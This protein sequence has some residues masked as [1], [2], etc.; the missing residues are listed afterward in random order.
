MKQLNDRLRGLR[1][2]EGELQKRKQHLLSKMPEIE[3]AYAMVSKLL[4]ADGEAM[5]LDFE[6]S[7]HVYTVAKLENV[8]TVNLWLGANVMVEYE[9][10]EANALL[11]SNLKIC[12]ANL[13]SANSDLDMI[14]ES[15]TTT[16]VSLAR[17]FNY[18]VE[19][20]R[21]IKEADAEMAKAVE[22]VSVSVD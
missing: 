13:A 6:L 9:L 16:E 11:E 20:R 7:P 3:K 15:S 19:R 8:K 5:S 17:V 18:D 22:G 10:S 21:K 1:L 2:I 14:K 12:K 4:E